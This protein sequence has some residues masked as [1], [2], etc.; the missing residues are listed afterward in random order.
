ME[1]HAEPEWSEERLK[2][3][4]RKWRDADAEATGQATLGVRT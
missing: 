4:V 1:R 2:A 3:Y